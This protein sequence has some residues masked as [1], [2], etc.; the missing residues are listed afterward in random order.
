LYRRSIESWPSIV[1][2]FGPAPGL[3]GDI[4]EEFVEGAVTSV[5]VGLGAYLVRARRE[6]AED[7]STELRRHHEGLRHRAP[8]RIGIRV[9]EVEPG[10]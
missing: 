6:I 9:P 4:L 3:S 5:L 7:D 1:S 2:H 8:N 10:T